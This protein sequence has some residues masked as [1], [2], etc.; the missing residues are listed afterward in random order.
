MSTPIFQSS[1]FAFE[2][3][4]H[5]AAVFRGEDASYVYT[6]LGNPTQAALE[7]EMAYLEKGEAALA[8]ASGMAAATT[9][10]LTCCQTGDHIVAGDT[11]YGG[12]HQLFTQTLPRLGINVTEVPADDPANFADA[13]TDK[14]KLIYLETP[15]NPTLVLTDIAAVAEIAQRQGHSRAGGQHLLH[16]LPAEPP[17]SGR[18]HR[19]ALGHQVHRRPRRH[20]GRHPGGQGRLD[21]AGPHGDPARRGRLHLPLQRLAA[22]ARPEDPA[23]AHGP[24]HGQ[25]H[26]GGPVPQL[27]PQGGA[28][29]STPA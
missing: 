12:T 21:H 9:A 17:G 11:L 4:E 20:G 5:G 15:A 1:T 8:L 22:A 28:R 23:G 25:R 19:P 13:I 24:A 14:T 26:G 29:S 18:G 16:A 27:P 7:T 3:A 2:N 6:R 10:V